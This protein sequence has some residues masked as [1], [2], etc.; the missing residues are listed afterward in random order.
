MSDA[1]DAYRA[2]QASKTRADKIKDLEQS[3]GSLNRRV[4][5]A[6][7]AGDTDK[8]KD[9]RSRQKNFVKDL[10]NE[11]AI[12][13]GGVMRSAPTSADDKG[14]IIRD[15]RGNPI[16]TTEGSQ[17]FQEN[18]QRNFLDPTRRLQNVNPDMYRE[19]YPMESRLRSGPFALQAAKNFFNI[20]QR[21]IPMFDPSFDTSRDLPL[22]L[23]TQ[24][25]DIAE[26]YSQFMDQQFP[27]DQSEAVE[28]NTIANE[29]PSYLDNVIQTGGLGELDG[30]NI[31]E[32]TD[33][34]MLR[35][36]IGIANNDIFQGNL[37]SEGNTIIG[38]AR[39]LRD[40][41]NKLDLG[42]NSGDGQGFDFNIG[43]R[44]VGFTTPLFNLPGNFRFSANPGGGGIMYNLGLGA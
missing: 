44:E 29:T 27:I 16:F 33:T 25:P 15:S 32:N 11:L 6:I 1:R 23:Q 39:G 18:M 7:K 14:R 5:N 12:Q 8:A 2:R 41:F 21:Q 31:L 34:D 28:R 19:M 30:F 40:A 22:N 20:P 37:G 38:G 9:L 10:G 13:S 36:G 4:E 3:V 35:N 43:D 26:S 42:F 17:V 24:N